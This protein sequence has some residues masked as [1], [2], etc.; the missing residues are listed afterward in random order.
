M[1]HKLNGIKEKKRQ[2]REEIIKRY[3]KR[4]ELYESIDENRMSKAKLKWNSL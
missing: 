3:P 4:K 2:Q 1:K